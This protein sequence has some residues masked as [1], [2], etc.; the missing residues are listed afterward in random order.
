MS[1]CVVNTSL[2]SVSLLIMQAAKA[3]KKT[4]RN[5]T[6]DA[7]PTLLY[8]NRLAVPRVLSER[9]AKRAEKKHVGGISY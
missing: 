3:F 7:V 9:R 1:V 6:K 8:F 5:T 4:K 2:R